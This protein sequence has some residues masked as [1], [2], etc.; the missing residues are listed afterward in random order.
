M[1]PVTKS[2][3]IDDDSL[4]EFAEVVQLACHAMAGDDYWEA[5]KPPG[6]YNVVC[7]PLE[8]FNC[9]QRSKGAP[10]YW[11]LLTDSE[12]LSFKCGYDQTDI[13]WISEESECKIDRRFYNLGKL[14]RDQA[15]IEGF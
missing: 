3:F 9:Y 10:S 14:F 5:P 11:E 12:Q 13:R 7:C 6:N 2:Q 4:S 1:Y 15:L 8:A